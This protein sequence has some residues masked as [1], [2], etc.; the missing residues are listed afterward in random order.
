MSNSNQFSAPLYVT[1]DPHENWQQAITINPV[2]RQAVI[3]KVGRAPGAAA[4]RAQTDVAPLSALAATQAIAQPARAELNSATDPVESLAV[5][6]AADPAL[7]PLQVSAV[8]PAIGQPV[9]I[10]ATVRNVG[11]D[12]ANNLV[13]TIYRGLPGSGTPIGV[14]N[15]SSSLAMNAFASVVF[16]LTTSGVNCRSTQK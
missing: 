1:D 11:R 6:A 8:V 7:D 16:T 2:S 15:L 13:V 9:T 3:L 10:T 4:H 5:V 14:Q 12:V